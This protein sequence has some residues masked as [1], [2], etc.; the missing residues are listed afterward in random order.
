LSPTI[1]RPDPST[2]TDVEPVPGRLTRQRLLTPR[3]PESV[4]HRHSQRRHLQTSQTTAPRTS[5]IQPWHHAHSTR[6]NRGTPHL[7]CVCVEREPKRDSM[8]RLAVAAA[9]P[10]SPPPPTL[11]SHTLHCPVNRC[12]ALT[13]CEQALCVS[14]RR[15]HEGEG[16]RVAGV[17]LLGRGLGDAEAGAG[18]SNLVQEADFGGD[19][20]AVLCFE[21]SRFHVEPVP[22]RLTRTR[23]LTPRAY[24]TDTVR[25]VD[26]HEAAHPEGVRHSH[27]QRRHLL[28]RRTDQR[29]S[30]TQ[31]WPAQL[32]LRR[33][34]RRLG[35]ALSH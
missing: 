1:P 6:G 27:R 7:P 9:P 13:V 26:T 16:D 28:A 8:R 33:P 11:H 32:C 5:Q 25:Q 29:T 23:L 31:A 35:Q 30:L 12:H 17:T 4:R 24:V 14:R 2:V 20:F 3:H 21:T 22:G 34:Q 19:K 18:S 15:C 10:P